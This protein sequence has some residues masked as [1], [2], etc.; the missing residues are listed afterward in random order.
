MFDDDPLKKISDALN[1]NITDN[2]E[3][4]WFYK[5]LFDAIPNLIFYKNTSGV[6][7]LCNKAFRDFLGLEEKDILD[8]G[9]YEVSPHEMATVYAEADLKLLKNKGIQTYETRLQYADGT[10]HD[11]V[12]SKGLHYSLSG[13]TI[14][15]IGIIHDISEKKAAERE[16]TMLHQL[17]DIFISIN[18]E[19]LTFQNESQLME[20]FLNQFV[21]IYTPCDQGTVLALTPQN[22]LRVIAQV[23][24]TENL[25]DHFEIP[26]EASFIWQDSP[27]NIYGAHVV[28][29]IHV[30][31]KNGAQEVSKLESNKEVASTLV[32]PIWIDERL[33]W[34]FALDSTENHVYDATDQKVAEYICAELPL[35]YRIFDLYL[36]T[37]EMSRYESLTGLINRRYFDEVFERFDHLHQENQRPYMM[38]MI[39]L[40]GLKSINDLYGHLAGDVYLKAFSSFLKTVHLGGLYVA[41]IGG[42]EF[43]VLF[44]G[45]DRDALK[46]KLDEARNHFKLMPIRH[47]NDVFYG[48]FSFGIAVCPDD[49]TDRSKL[50]QI[51]DMYMYRDKH[52]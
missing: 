9:I 1:L 50:F 8:K 20:A 46:V 27:G 49:A 21:M 19:M 17:K 6:Y 24:Y 51:S 11:I 47:E 34:I 30:Y 43:A 5:T 25:V 10:F 22:T 4:L 39:D 2:Q 33:K 37:L 7:K 29:D 45:D 31:V 28:N 13:E 32:V 18:H 44:E 40:D 23:G 36:K 42:D 15:I 12:T 35:L 41:R 48:N 14:G 26:F 3:K 16:I 38:V 52:R